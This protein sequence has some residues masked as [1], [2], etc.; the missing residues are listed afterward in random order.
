MNYKTLEL[1]SEYVPFIKVNVLRS[2]DLENEQTLSIVNNYSDNINS[3]ILDSGVWFKHKDPNKYR[4]AVHNVRLYGE[5]VQEHGEKFDFYFNYDEDFQEIYRDEFS[6]KNGDNLKI[7]ESMGLTPVPVL[8]LL[9]DDLVQYHI[10]QKDKYPLLAIGSNKVGDNKFKTVVNSLKDNGIRVHGFRLGSTVK[11]TGLAAWSVDCSSHAQWTSS[12]RAVIFDKLNSKDVGI[13]FR[14]FDKAGDISE[15]YFQRHPLLS[16][17]IWFLEEFVGV[18]LEALVKDSN[19]RTL[20]NSIYYWWLEQ[21]ITL[22]NMDIPYKI[23]FDDQNYDRK[24]P[25][26]SKLFEEQDNG[27]SIDS[28]IQD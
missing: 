23:I 19:Y 25:M 15:D 14:P 5:F 20:S 9:D 13:S 7:L 4:D 28:W 3:I 24:N 2:F 10:E 1:I 26:L 17:F 8:H 18:E 12:G 11:L 16:D 27:E 22:K 21:Y 6:S